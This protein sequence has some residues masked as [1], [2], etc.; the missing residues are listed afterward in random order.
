MKKLLLLSLIILAS[1]GD[2]EPIIEE[3]PCD[4]ECW[5]LLSR[6]FYDD[7]LHGVSGGQ[8][9]FRTSYMYTIKNICTGLVKERQSRYFYTGAPQLGIII[10]DN[11]TG[12]ITWI[13]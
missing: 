13:D 3:D 6:E 10:C 12:D 4:E 8:Q 7:E 2:N 1:C 9:V 11:L 5:E